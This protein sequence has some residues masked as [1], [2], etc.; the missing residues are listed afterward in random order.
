[1]FC[2]NCG[3]NIDDK[4]AVCIHC[5]A[6]TANFG[7]KAPVD[8]NESPN[9]G[10]VVLAILVPVFGIVMGIIETNNGKKRAGKAYL[11]AAIATT[12]FWVLFS[13]IIVFISTI[14]PLFIV[15][16]AG[17]AEAAQNH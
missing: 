17:T 7:G 6:P 14:L 2:S 12:V 4:A 8:P 15:L 10:F 16:I 1:M 13:L 9:S 5:G 3:K 11:T